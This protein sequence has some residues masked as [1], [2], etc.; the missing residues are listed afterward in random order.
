[1]PNCCN[2]IYFRAAVVDDKPLTSCTLSENIIPRTAKVCI[3]YQEPKEANEY[4]GG[5]YV[6]SH[7]N[8]QLCPE[9]EEE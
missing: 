5:F 3:F 2:C 6:N 8:I 1:M 9:E 7:V 4:D